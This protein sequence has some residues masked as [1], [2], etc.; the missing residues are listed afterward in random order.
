M[1]EASS[2][3]SGNEEKDFSCALSLCSGFKADTGLN[4]SWYFVW[5]LFFKPSECKGSKILSFFPVTSRAVLKKW[6]S[7]HPTPVKQKYFHSETV[8]WHHKLKGRC[9]SPALGCLL[10][11]GRTV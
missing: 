2:T 4:I 5:F 8:I 6:N 9:S 7:N 10:E 1:Q 3:E 11:V